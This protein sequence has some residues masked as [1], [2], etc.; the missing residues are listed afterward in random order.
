MPKKFKGV[1]TKA[2]EARAR[3]AD[4]KTAEKEKK[5][6]DAED[7]LW[8]DDDKHVLKKQQRKASN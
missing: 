1:N 4:A 8:E 7:K 5:E 3:K 2:E 6:R